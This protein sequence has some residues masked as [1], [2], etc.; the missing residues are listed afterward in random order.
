MHVLMS[1]G[2]MML[3][4]RVS[5]RRDART[6]AR[7]MLLSGGPKSPQAEAFITTIINHVIVPARGRKVQA[8]PTMQRRYREALGPFLADLLHARAVGRW[9]KLRTADVALRKYPGTPTAFKA[10]RDAMGGQG[11]LEELKGFRYPQAEGDESFVQPPSAPTS[12]R[13]TARLLQMAEEHGVTISNLAAHFSRGKAP[14]PTTCDVIEARAMKKSLTP[15]ARRAEKVQR[16]P[17]DPTDRTASALAT[18]MQG[19]NAF[20]MEDGRIEGIAFAGLR[21]LY[22]K[23]D[24]PGF[25]WQWGGRFYSMPRADAYESLSDS[26]K[27]SGAGR[28]ARKA[29]L[30]INSEEVEEVDLSAAHLTILHGLL[31]L[32]FAPD[33]ETYSFPDIEREDVKTWIMRALGTSSPDGGGKRYAR[34]RR[35]AL[36]RFPVLRGLG[37]HGIS[38][39]DLQY[40]E[41][42][43]MMMAMKDLRA[44]G[45]G[46]LPVHDALC[47]PRSKR[48]IAAVALKAAFA[49]YFTN[50]LGMPSPPVPRIH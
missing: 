20:L 7:S 46:F 29:T 42:E 9:S 3:P 17:I 5:D 11:L 25:A 10:L 26:G 2:E 24:Q 48:D 16:V 41:A 36:E 22:S 33:G 1:L 38:T 32:P 47:V 45:I 43:I 37:G 4:E 35:A 23:A 28:R 8:R 15:Q 12:F 44:Q 50:T 39:H 14:P 30:R 34:A 13:P 19:L 18:E 31:G 6:F 27:D 21:R 49:R 40:H